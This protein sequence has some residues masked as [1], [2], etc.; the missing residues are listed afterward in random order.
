[1]LVKDLPAH[2]A[3]SHLLNDYPTALTAEATYETKTGTRKSVLVT[4][5]SGQPPETRHSNHLGCTLQPIV[6]APIGG[7]GSKVVIWYRKDGHVRQRSVPGAVPVSSGRVIFTQDV[8][9]P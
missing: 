4:F 1:M 6:N 8:M 7:V 2:I 3:P 9:R 5:P